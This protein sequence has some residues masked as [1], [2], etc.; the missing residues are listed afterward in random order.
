MSIVK[1]TACILCIFMSNWT[2]IIKSFKVTNRKGKKKA[3]VQSTFTIPV[4]EATLGLQHS[5]WVEHMQL[6]GA[7]TKSLQAHLAP[8]RRKCTVIRFTESGSCSTRAWAQSTMSADQTGLSDPPRPRSPHPQ[9]H[10]TPTIPPNR[11]SNSQVKP[12]QISRALRGIDRR[13]RGEGRASGMA[14]IQLRTAVADE[15]QLDEVIVV[16]PSPRRRR[17]HR[18]PQ[19]PH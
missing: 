19:S 14:Q 16:G 10:L 6:V 11:N 18:F 7:C 9:T 2:L 8:K 4:L 5:S 15:E 17:R 13:A 3:L 12:N 1:I